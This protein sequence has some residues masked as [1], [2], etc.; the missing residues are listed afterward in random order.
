MQTQDEVVISRPIEH[1]VQAGPENRNILKLFVCSFNNWVKCPQDALEVCADIGNAL[2]DMILI[3]DDIQ[4]ETILRRG[5]PSAHM[6]YGI[7]LTVHAT[8]YKTFL[9]M[10]NLLYY[11]ENRKD[12]ALDDFVK[13]G[14]RFFTG[15]GLEIYY[16]DIERCPTFHE[17]S[18]LIRGKSTAVLKWGVHWLKFCAKKSKMEF[19]EDLYNK[20]GLVLQLYDDYVNLHNAK[21]A[22]VRVF[23]DDLDE[24]KFNFPI[25]H[26]IQSHPNDHR[27]LDML[28]Q[29]PLDMESK[30]L[31]V[32]ILESFGSFEY[33]RKELE[34]LKN[35]I[36]TD[37]DNMN[38]G[39][40][41]Y[42][43]RILEDVLGNLETEI[44]Y[45]CC[46]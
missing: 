41:P 39:K 19:S 22:T 21:Y 38:M 18:T 32:D 33:T 25:I 43:E 36:L 10:Q 46:D 29:R 12:I 35:G 44:Y 30:K 16:R 7:P 11:A 37:A 4:D 20:I 23:C 2:H 17:Y 1:I 8:L 40:N 13:L 24:G 27:L 34:K 6:V 3:L 9:I 15:Q 28:K 45:D 31:F 26:G 14:I 5:L 42:L